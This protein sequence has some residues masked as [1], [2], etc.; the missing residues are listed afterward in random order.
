MGVAVLTREAAGTGSP[1][2]VTVRCPACGACATVVARFGEIVA[3]Y[4]LCDPGDDRRK[5]RYPM[6]MEP[7]GKE[8]GAVLAGAAAGEKRKAAR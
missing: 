7:L 1:P 6:R 8:P 4:H 5:L 2:S 3:V